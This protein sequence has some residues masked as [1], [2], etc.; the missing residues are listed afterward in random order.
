MRDALRSLT[1]AESLAGFDEAVQGLSRKI[2]QIV[3]TSQ[4]P[5][6]LQQ[7]EAA[8]F[9]AAL[10]RLARCL[11]RCAARLSDEVR[12]LAAKIEHIAD[13]GMREG[14]D[15]LSNLE[16][17]VATLAHALEAGARNEPAMPPKLEALIKTLSDKIEQMELSRGDHLALG[18]LEDRIVKLVEKLDANDSRLGHLGAI[19]RGLADL[20]VKLDELRSGNGRAKSVRD[21]DAPAR[22]EVSELKRDIAEIKD[23]QSASE[24]RAKD[25][26]A[27][28]PRYARPGL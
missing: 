21:S 5:R 16:Q 26:P 6:A 17:R 8:D 7:L 19:E 3:A 14:A 22:T 4:D 2:D 13:A 15:A 24:Q 12:G 11:R 25:T 10:R 1:P 28:G 20:L 18:S 9:R 23:I 27:G